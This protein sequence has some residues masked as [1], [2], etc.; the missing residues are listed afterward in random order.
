MWIETG[1]AVYTGST[2]YQYADHPLSGDT[3][4][5]TPYRASDTGFVP[6]GN[7]RNPT[8]TDQY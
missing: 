1:F 6:G 7:G 5:L 4:H 8:V 3:G 2:R